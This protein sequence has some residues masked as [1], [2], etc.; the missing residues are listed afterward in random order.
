M[1]C[2]N[3]SKR[4]PGCHSTCE[5]Y[6]KQQEK[7]Q[8]IREERQRINNQRDYEFKSVMRISNKK[9]HYKNPNKK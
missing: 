5:D 9:N 2:F 3:C 4:E 6:K 8:K 7:Y 1:S